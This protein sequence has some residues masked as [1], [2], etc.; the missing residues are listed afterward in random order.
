MEGILE[1][2]QAQRECFNVIGSEA[3]RLSRL[4]EEVLSISQ[5][6]VG[7]IRLKRGDVELSRLIR[8][9]VKELQ[10]V[11]DEKSIELRL[12]L[13]A[14]LPTL[15]G[16]KEKLAV[17]LNNLLGNAIK[18]APSGGTVTIT[19]VQN[20]TTAEI[21]IADTGVGI[22]PEDQDKIFDK[23]YRVQSE[24]VQAQRGTGLGLTTAREIA[25]L[26]GGDITLRSELGKGSTFLLVLPL[27]RSTSEALPSR[28]ERS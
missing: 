1:D 3:R 9:G 6:E 7:A 23:F 28:A 22:A 18:Y 25:R 27:G 12:R 11:A 14:K 10:G 2:P 20:E 13:P 4:I 19:C 16:D 21:E 17:A 26:H 15:Q 8:E 24:E 5:L